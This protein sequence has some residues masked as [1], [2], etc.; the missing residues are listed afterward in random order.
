MLTVNWIETAVFVVA[1]ASPADG[2]VNVCAISR[3]DPSAPKVTKFIELCF[4]DQDTPYDAKGYIM[5]PALK[6]W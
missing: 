6:A 1:Y 4:P 2:S 3:E 5:S